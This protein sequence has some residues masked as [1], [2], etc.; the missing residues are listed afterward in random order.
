MQNAKCPEWSTG[1]GKCRPL[2][3]LHS[4]RVPQLAWPSMAWMGTFHAAQGSI[5][6]KLIHWNRLRMCWCISNCLWSDCAR[7]A[8]GSNMKQLASEK[9]SKEFA[10]TFAF[11]LQVE[12]VDS[13]YRSTLSVQ[14][15][16]V[17]AQAILVT[18]RDTKWLLRRLCFRSCTQSTCLGLRTLN[19]P[20]MPD[21]CQ[22]LLHVWCTQCTQPS[23]PWT[24]LN[25][26]AEGALPSAAGDRRFD[27]QIS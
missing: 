23:A 25:P 4:W 15:S 2:G 5:T 19:K 9:N 18:C 16:L 12:K 11:E 1:H 6:N 26:G 8:S 3:L 21:N 14:S 27:W 17:C 10:W 22:H 13:A 20:S 7:G 24:V